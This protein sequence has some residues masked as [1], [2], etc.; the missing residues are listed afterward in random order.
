MPRG[1]S[2]PACS[3]HRYVET[4]TGPVDCPRCVR[5]YGCAR[6]GCDSV[7]PDY[8]SFGAHGKSWCLGH[9]P[10]WARIRVWWQERGSW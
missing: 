5:Y 2:C 1:K 10:L 6:R 9:R 4:L 8:L 7:N 3:G